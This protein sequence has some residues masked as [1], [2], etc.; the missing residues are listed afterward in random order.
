MQ[1]NASE[2]PYKTAKLFALTHSSKLWQILPKA[3]TVDDFLMLLLII[4]DRLSHDLQYN[5]D[6]FGAGD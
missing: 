6:E 4:Q 2:I 5:V 1:N 3:K